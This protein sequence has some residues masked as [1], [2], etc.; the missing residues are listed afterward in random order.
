MCG[1]FTA[2]SQKHFATSNSDD[3]QARGQSLYNK[4]EQDLKIRG[5]D[6]S[7]WMVREGIFFSHARLSIIDLIS[8]QQPMESSDKS[9]VVVF[10]GEIYNFQD[11]RRRNAGYPF[12]TKSDTECLFTINDLNDPQDFLEDLRG[13]F[14]FVMADFRQKKILV[15]RDRFG[16][17]P[18][19]VSKIGDQVFFS[20]RIKSIM[21]ASDDPLKISNYGLGYYLDFGFIPAP[22]SIISGIEKLCPGEWRVYDLEGQL[23]SSGRISFFSENSLLSA[24][25]QQIDSSNLTL[26]LK[27][28]TKTRLISERP[29]GLLLSDGVDSSVLA[30]IYQSTLMESTANKL[31]AYIFESPDPNL[32]ESVGAADFATKIGLDFDIVKFELSDSNPI[33]EILDKLD[34]PFADLSIF[35]TYL[36]YKKLKESAT[37]AITGDGGDELF[38][39]YPY[40]FQNNFA[41]DMFRYQGIEHFPLRTW[42]KIRE[43]PSLFSRNSYLYHRLSTSGLV[44]SVYFDK[45]AGLIPR[46]KDR[47]EELRKK[48]PE[49]SFGKDLIKS[50]WNNTITLGLCDRMLVKVDIC[51]MAAGV[52]ARSPFL[53]EDLW[54]M[55]MK[56]NYVQTCFDQRVAKKKLI[57]YASSFKTIS[58]KRGFSMNYEKLARSLNIK[59]PT[60]SMSKL[61]TSHDPPA[62]TNMILTEWINK[63]GVSV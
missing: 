9:R 23:Q 63:N 62:L 50:Q 1:F 52:E 60:L 13:M 4:I 54:V 48:R 55:I 58:T 10:N 26:A 33:S 47:F 37:V 22:F 36:V 59:K 61:R 41:L 51:S 20:S 27:Q 34:E 2:I 29:I 28:A 40:Q 25:H 39:G 30:K 32:N 5:P 3:L 42:R 11:I 14:S 21:K 17:K 53:D 44:N 18:L 15:A 12:H 46:E 6:E 16:K 43:L 49:F 7:R 35:P 8:G 31:K 19:F 56:S 38:G 57:E 45:F 24:D